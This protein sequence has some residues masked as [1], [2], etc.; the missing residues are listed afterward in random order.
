METY[1]SRVSLGTS[2]SLSAVDDIVQLWNGWTLEVS[3]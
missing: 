2:G 3:S 1:R